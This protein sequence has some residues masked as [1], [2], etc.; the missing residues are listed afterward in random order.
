MQKKESLTVRTE[1]FSAGAYDRNVAAQWDD[2]HRYTPAPRHRRRMMSRI[3][4]DLDFQDCLDAGCAQLYFLQEVVRRH[5]VVGYG[6]DISD[7]VIANNQRL[8][9]DCNFLTLDLSR[10]TWPQGRQFDLV[11]CSEV[12]EHIPDWRSAL[13]N[14]VRMS[15]RYLLITVPSGKIRTI[16]RM[17][18][19]HYHFQG[20]ELTS[21]L[22]VLGCE[23]VHVRKWGFPMHSLYKILINKLSPEKLYESFSDTRYGFFRRLFSHALYMLF[24]LNEF[25]NSGDQLILLARKTHRPSFE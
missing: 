20:P 15:R 6:C 12:L 5:G 18:G 25:S 16:D 7:E 4:V 17:V 22:Q 11:V 1:Q 14:L 19:H 10:E 21:E 2:A 23:V 13:S 8:A 24:Y 3:I 9:P